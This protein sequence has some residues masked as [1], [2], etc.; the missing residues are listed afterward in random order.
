LLARL[1]ALLLG[2]TTRLVLEHATPPMLLA[3]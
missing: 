2:G 3:H 1:R